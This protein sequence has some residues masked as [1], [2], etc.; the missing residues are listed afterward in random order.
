MCFI[1]KWSTIGGLHDIIPIIWFH[2]DVDISWLQR[3][4]GLELLPDHFMMCWRTAHSVISMISI[5][6]LVGKELAF[7]WLSLHIFP[8]SCCPS[9]WYKFQILLRNPITFLSVFR[10]T[11]FL[12]WLISFI[13][14]PVCISFICSNTFP[15]FEYISV[16]QV[17]HLHIWMDI[18][19]KLST[20]YNFALKINYLYFI[21][22]F[23][24]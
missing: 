5:S 18:S 23:I 16:S 3:R 7:L 14:K 10:R 11:V 6:V 21:L 13:E 17:I 20:N 15:R 9:A 8:S 4:V 19:I 22:F 12:L 2:I 24:I 1:P